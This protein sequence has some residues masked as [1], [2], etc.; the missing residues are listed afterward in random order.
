MPKESLVLF[1]PFDFEI[2]QKITIEAGPRYGDWEVIGYSERKVKLRC[3]ITHREV[4][5]DRFCYFV[6]LREDEEWPHQH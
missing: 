5:W 4:E 1:R 2:G 6:E 3:P